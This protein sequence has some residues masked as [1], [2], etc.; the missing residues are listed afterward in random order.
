MGKSLYCW[1]G[2][3]IIASRS[4]ASGLG[5]TSTII[6]MSIVED[7]KVDEITLMSLPNVYSKKSKFDF[8]I[9]GKNK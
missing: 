7:G 2:S 5:S 3:I 9:K 6:S 4:I 1:N 8:I